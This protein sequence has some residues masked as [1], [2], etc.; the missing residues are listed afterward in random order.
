MSS[1]L[2]FDTSTS[3]LTVAVTTPHDVL[4]ER[5]AAPDASGRP[6]HARELMRAVEGA[7]D[8]AG[9]WERISGLAV[10]LGPGTFTGLRIGVATARA[11]AQAREL[12]LAGV[13]SLRALASGAASRATATLAVLD[14]KRGEAFVA[15]YGDG[16]EIWAPW[17]GPPGELA[18]RVGAL[19][20]APLAVGEGAIR[21]RGQLEAAG[22]IVPA[23]EDSAHRLR[24]RHVCRLAAEAEA[25]RPDLIQPTYLRRPDAELWRE[26]DRGS[27]NDH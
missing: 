8:D 21:F 11:L 16:A 20:H 15:L 12:P 3:E 13:S 17:V 6:R 2:G 27:R 7:L 23:D 4:A 5:E 25:G 9:G 22:A 1:I 10:G 19:G 14:A 26:R 24:A 18:E